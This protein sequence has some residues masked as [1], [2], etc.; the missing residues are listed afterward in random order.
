MIKQLEIRIAGV[1]SGILLS[2]SVHVLTDRSNEIVAK[3][4]W[5]HS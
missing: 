3:I 5:I 2:G 1:L 4:K